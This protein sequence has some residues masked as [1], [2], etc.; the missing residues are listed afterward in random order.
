M[1]MRQFPR[2]TVFAASAAGILALGVFAMKPP[3][4]IR[5][6]TQH[7]PPY[8]IV[9]ETGINGETVDV[10]RCTLN[11]LGKP[12]RIEIASSW[13]DAQNQVRTG[14]AQI[15]FGA[16]HT[17]ERDTYGVWT[18]PLGFHQMHYIGLS[19]SGLDPRAVSSRFALKLAAGTAGQIAGRIVSFYGQDNPD[20]VRAIV[21]G[22]ADFVYMDDKVF[23]YAALASGVDPKAFTK[24]FVNPQAYASYISR[25][26]SN[27]HPGF[28]ED[29]NNAAGECLME[30]DGINRTEVTP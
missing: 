24:Y 28:V 26:Y 15:M 11:R 16:L 30:R 17:L 22:K 8:Q 6:L 23:A 3:V 7:Y 29:F 12:Y 1:P 9:D 21:E 20:L 13:G 25:E 27:R 19:G 5:A 10:M 18:T 14:E 4:P 2:K